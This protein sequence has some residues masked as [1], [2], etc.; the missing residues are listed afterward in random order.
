LFILT[1]N[2]KK[3]QIRP[4]EKKIHSSQTREEKKIKLL[5]KTKQRIEKW[6]SVNLSLYIIFNSS[7]FISK[8]FFCFQGLYIAFISS[9]LSPNC[10]GLSFF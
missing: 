4:K 7:G 3:V 6:L 9:V 2:K 5:Q 8:L 10:F 1:L